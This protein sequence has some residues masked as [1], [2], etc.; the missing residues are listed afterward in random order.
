MKVCPQC[1]TKYTDDTLKFC[2]QDGNTLEIANDDKTLVFDQDSFANDDTIA[3]NFSNKT[4]DFQGKTEAFSHKQTSEESQKTEN[5]SQGEHLSQVTIERPK[6]FV[7][8]TTSAKQATTNKKGGLGFLSGLLIGVLLIGLVGIGV[9]AVIFLPSIF[10]KTANTN[11]NSNA[12]TPTP[13]KEITL[14]NSDNVKI[15]ASSSRKA[16]KGN[17]YQPE[18]AFDGNSRTAWSEGARGAGI[19]QW[20]VFDFEKEVNLKEIIIEPGYF[21]TDELW[22]K[23]NRLSSANFKFSNGKSK[24]FKFTDKMKEQKVDVGNVKTKS[25]MITIKDI[26]PGQTDSKDTL[27]SEVKFVV[28]KE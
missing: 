24:T 28:Q 9:L 5:L 18:L 26:Y 22:R 19:G 4:E 1:H 10:S 13:K 11:T 14:N 8:N 23:N 15:S 20:I 3:E 12:V 25:V 27:I 21:K 2:L 6:Q 17:F 16:E 7:E